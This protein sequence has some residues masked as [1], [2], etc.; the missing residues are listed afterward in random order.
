MFR[1]VG[2]LVVVASVFAVGYYAG[3]HRIHDLKETVAA[4]SRHAL[5]TALGMGMERNLEW[6]EGLIEAKARVIQAKSELI[7]RNFG[8]AERELADALDS[9]QTARR[10]ER[11]P[12]RIA[13][14]KSLAGRIRQTKVRMAA[15]KTV[16]RTSLDEI[17]RELDAL[18]AQ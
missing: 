8:N 12:E 9:L 6:R 3:Q 11:D 17:Q 2:F 15:G 1:L 4:L 5:D 7:D 13:S 18:L 14:A 16:A 10:G